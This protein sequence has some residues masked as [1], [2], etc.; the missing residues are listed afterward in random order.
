MNKSFF[1][2]LI[3]FFSQLTFAQNYK[4]G[5]GSQFILNLGGVQADL[6]IYFADVNEKSVSIEYYITLPNSFIPVK[7]WQQFELGINKTGP[8]N[9]LNGYVKTGNMEK[10]EK[11]TSDYLHVNEGVEVNDF[12]FADKA[13]FEKDKVGVDKIKTPAGNVTA[14]HYRKT[15]NNQTIDF[16]ISDEAKPLGLVKLNSTNPQKPE[17]NFQIELVNM[18]KNVKPT[19]D[20]KAAIPLTEKGK[21]VLANPIKVALLP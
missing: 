20:P 19:I 6:S 2:L 1:Y 8:L 3:A 15:R 17:Q 21:T 7:M 14:N 4:S 11:L 16:W 5:E 18:I 10:A 9:V 13:T 12:L